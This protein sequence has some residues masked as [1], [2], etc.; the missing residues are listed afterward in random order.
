M[1]TARHR[2]RTIPDHLAAVARLGGNAALV[3]EVVGGCQP[4]NGTFRF[5]VTG[6][7]GR[8]A[9][10]GGAD[11]GFQ[12]GRLHLSLDGRPQSV[13]EGEVASMPDLAANVAGVY[14]DLRD[15]IN[16]GT[17]TVTDFRHAVRLTRFI[18]DVTAS[19]QTRTRKSAAD[20]PVQ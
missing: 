5:E 3:V 17:R 7:D 13:D 16:R 19:A 15:D 9:L 14:V 2:P 10:D 20:W 1:T 18:T 8:L 4:G 11:R 6:T 12:S